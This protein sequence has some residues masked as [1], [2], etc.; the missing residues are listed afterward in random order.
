V[1][2]VSAMGV[3]YERVDLSNILSCFFV[4]DR[5]QNTACPWQLYKNICQ[6]KPATFIFLLGIHGKSPCL[7]MTI[8]MN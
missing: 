1:A 7:P 4:A 2:V 5:G 3:L 8:I 6:T